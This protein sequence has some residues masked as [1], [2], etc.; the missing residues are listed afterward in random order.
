MYV[1]VIVISWWQ[2]IGSRNLLKSVEKQRETEQ[3]QLQ[4][5]MAEKKVQLERYFK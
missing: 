3:Q 4:A 5:L 2:A 1:Q